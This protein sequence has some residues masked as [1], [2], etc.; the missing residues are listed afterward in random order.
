MVMKSSLA[1][2][3]NLAGR[4]Y[5]TDSELVF[6]KKHIIPALWQLL[7]VCSR[8]TQGVYYLDGAGVLP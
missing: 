7:L 1:H 2:S 6:G 8:V 4:L 5:W 3:D